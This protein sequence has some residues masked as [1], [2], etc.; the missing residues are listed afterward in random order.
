MALADAET[1]EPD[2]AALSVRTGGT[3]LV[4]APGVPG[5]PS[6]V[7]PASSVDSGAACGTPFAME[8][9]VPLLCAADAAAE[10]LPGPAARKAA[11]S[12]GFDQALTAGN[13]AGSTSR[14]PGLAPPFCLP[15]TVCQPSCE[16]HQRE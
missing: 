5:R 4:D 13:G 7:E 6:E 2:E 10:L 1:K 16:V 8:A 3:A 11:G 15:V 12:S 14:G 9:A